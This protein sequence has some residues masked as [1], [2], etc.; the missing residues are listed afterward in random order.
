MARVALVLMTALL[1]SACGKSDEA[2]TPEDPA[3]MAQG[4]QTFRLICSTCHNLTDPSNG[5]GPYLVHLKGRKA[6]SVAGFAYTDAMRNAGVVWDEAT[7]GSFLADPSAFIPG[8]AMVIEPLSDPQTRKA[9]V[10]Y[11][12]HQ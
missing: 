8:T 1:L 7:L 5:T 6:G 3:L 4:A 2:Q 9:L 11:L 12:T 10:H